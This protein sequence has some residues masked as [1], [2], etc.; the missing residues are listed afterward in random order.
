MATRLQTRESEAGFGVSTR[1]GDGGA[2]LELG[3]DPLLQASDRDLLRDASDAAAL[4]ALG[5]DGIHPRT[6]AQL[7]TELVASVRELERRWSDA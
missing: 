4:L 6:A 7:R 2:Q 5:P 3:R 1:T